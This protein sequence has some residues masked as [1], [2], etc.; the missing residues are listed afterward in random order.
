MQTPNWCGIKKTNFEPSLSMNIH[1]NRVRLNNLYLRS[2]NKGKIPPLTGF[3]VM[4]V[5][6]NLPTMQET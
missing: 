5:V 3:Q 2:L 6:K 4:L 1:I